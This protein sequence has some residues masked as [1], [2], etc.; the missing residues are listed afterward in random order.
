V[1]RTL[2]VGVLALAL[3]SPAGGARP[4][5][6][7]AAAAI[8]AA[9]K[10]GL[11]AQSPAAF[12]PGDPF[13]AGDLSAL[14]EA[15]G[16][17]RAAPPADPSAPVTIAGL[18][19]AMVDALGLRA[20][21]RAF[22]AGARAAGLKPP[23]RFGSEVTARML[24]LHTDLP[25]KFDSLELQ[26]QQP[27]TRADAAFSAAR[28]L[29]LGREVQGGIPAPDLTPLA[30]A[31]AG[32]GVQYIRG[33]AATFMLPR[34]TPVEQEVLH[35]AVSLIGYP[36]V[37]GGENEKTE[38]GF[39]CSGFV[40]RVFKGATYPDAPGLGDVI[41]GRTA[42][43]MAGEV[44]RSERIGR[45][46]LQPGDVLFFGNG[47]RSKPAQVGHT[48]IY[49]GNGWLI[50]S[51]GQGVSLGRLEWYLKTFAWAR[52]PLAEATADAATDLGA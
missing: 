47:R 50:E 30:A 49:L 31:D 18:D 39:D 13:T 45:D 25:V 32:W 52:R 16:K 7:W 11:F 22:N 10:A 34:L 46:D 20:T 19:R 38:I 6:S 36:Y 42:A 5:P 12:R 4:A 44:P 9:T 15:L 27:A 24:G 37:W 41:K 40:W 23:A 17:P 1:R 8:A 33:L 21:A 28:I 43:Q 51:S 3:V 48:S 14:L 29:S 26:P 2:V 35:A